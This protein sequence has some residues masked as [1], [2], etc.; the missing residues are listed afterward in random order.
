MEFTRLTEDDIL[1]INDKCPYEWDVNVQ[2]IFKQPMGVPNNIKEPVIYRCYL[3]GES[4]GGSYRDGEIPRYES[5]DYIPE[6][7][8]LD[9][10]LKKLNIA[11]DQEQ[12]G[13]VHSLMKNNMNTEYHDYYGNYSD[14]EYD[15]ILLEDFYKLINSFN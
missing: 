2:G 15:Y 8:A 6:F 1:E 11:L 10:V 14:I 4:T 9:L 12:L 13:K 5:I 3:S 7:V